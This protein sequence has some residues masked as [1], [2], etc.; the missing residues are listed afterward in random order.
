MPKRDKKKRNLIDISLIKSTVCDAKEA[1][2]KISKACGPQLGEHTASRYRNR[3]D[4]NKRKGAVSIVSHTILEEI[5]RKG[6][7]P[8]LDRV[9]G[10]GGSRGVWKEFGF[11]FFVHVINF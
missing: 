2:E 10:G 6:I 11:L 7:Q 3:R 9:G 8:R 5:F 1:N 4:T